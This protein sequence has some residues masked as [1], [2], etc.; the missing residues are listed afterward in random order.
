MIPGLPRADQLHLH[1]VAAT[2]PDFTGSSFGEAHHVL[3]FP[4]RQADGD[5]PTRLRNTLV[6]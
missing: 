6:K 2:L 5:T 4:L 1:R 3:T